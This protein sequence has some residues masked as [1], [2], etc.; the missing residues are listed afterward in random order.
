[1]P[2]LG[3]TVLPSDDD[4]ARPRHSTPTPHEPTPSS[5]EVMPRASLSL[6]APFWDTVDRPPSSPDFASVT[7]AVP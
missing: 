6:E 3:F 1:M 7:P 4:G 5:L 2:L